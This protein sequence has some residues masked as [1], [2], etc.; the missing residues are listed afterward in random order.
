MKLSKLTLK[1]I[2]PVPECL[3][4]LVKAIEESRGVTLAINVNAK[5]K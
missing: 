3:M 4:P 5:G 1:L 2:R